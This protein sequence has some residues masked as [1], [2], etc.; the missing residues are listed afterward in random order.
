MSW[1]VYRM[2][3]S[4]LMLGLVGFTSQIPTFFLAPFAGVAADRFTRRRIVLI[5]QALSMIEAFFLTYLVVSGHVRIEW[6]FVLSAVMGFLTAFDVPARQS[7]VIE[8]IGK[9]EDLGNAI[10]LNSSLF[11]GARLIGPSVAGALIALGGEA[12]C[13][14]INGLSYL[15]VILAITAMRMP[16]RKRTA[17]PYPI[18]QGLRL[19]FTYALRSAPI[20]G[21]LLLLALVS[22]TGL[23][24]LVLLPIFAKDVLGGGPQTLGFLTAATGIGALLA[25]LYLAWQRSVK[26]LAK[27]IAFASFVFGISL[28]GFSLSRN[29]WISA[30]FL[31]LAGF[32]MMMQTVAS[33][34]ILQ[35][36]VEDDMRGRVMS[37]FT[38]AL[39]GMTPFGSLCSGWLAGR[40]GATRALALGGLVCL[41]GACVFLSR[42]PRIR[43]RLREVYAEKGIPL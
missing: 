4:P 13:F 42:L 19:G 36:L 34:T 9:K 33:N 10:A 41:A 32:G 43:S 16:A 22:F 11:N 24:Y 6:I 3:H 1:L 18:L 35:T 20:R 25:A 23:P 37:F 26:G 7:F 2:T 28:I 17:A 14:F 38:M 39:M 8:M 12:L 30:G 40:F 29:V 27:K 21:I 31:A 5:T 15:A